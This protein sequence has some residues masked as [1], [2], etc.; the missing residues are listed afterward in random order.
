MYYAPWCGHCKALK[1]I[2]NELAEEVKDSDLVI[3]KIDMTENGLFDLK[4]QGYPS[5]YFYPSDGEKMLY[6]SDRDLKSFMNYVYEH[7]EAFKKAYPDWQPP[8]KSEPI[9]E[10]QDE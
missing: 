5:I 10:S 4:I 2:W 1:P 8:K 3:A 7:S 6:D 9:P